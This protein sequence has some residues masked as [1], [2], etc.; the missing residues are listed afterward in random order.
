MVSHMGLQATPQYWPQAIGAKTLLSADS[1]VRPDRK[2]I[3]KSVFRR[4]SHR[5]AAGPR[6]IARRPAYGTSPGGRPTG[7]R[8]AAPAVLGPARRLRRRRPDGA[9]SAG[10]AGP[11]AAA[12]TAQPVAKR[13]Y[14][15][16]G[17]RNMDV[18]RTVTYFRPGPHSLK[19]AEWE[20][21]LSGRCIPEELRSWSTTGYP[22]VG[23]AGPRLVAVIARFLVNGGNQVVNGA[24]AITLP[25]AATS[26]RPGGLPRPP[27]RAAPR[28]GPCAIGPWASRD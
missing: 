14:F 10:P 21:R 19:S 4:R 6:D 26:C 20:E 25:L 1:S 5:P 24:Q 22:P 23:K 27:R 3:L 16:R 17:P 15:R 7:H 2:R 8:P 28:M 11:G 9:R 12:S 18:S 13:G